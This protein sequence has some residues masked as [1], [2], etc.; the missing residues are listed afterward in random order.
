MPAWARIA[1]IAWLAIYVPVYAA[2]Y[3]ALHFLQLCD[4]G[5]LLA[6]LG[7][8]LGNRLLLSAQAIGAPG[9]ALLW[10]ADLGWTAISGH[11]LH[12]GTA[13]LWDASVPALARVLSLFHLVLPIALVLYL[14]R[15][16]Y[17]PRALP[18]QS[19]IAAAAIA[20]SW[21]FGS[22]QNLNYVTH[23]PNGAAVL[24]AIAG[25]HAFA[26]WLSLC[27]VIYLPTHLS[28]LNFLPAKRQAR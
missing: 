27:A 19:A 2:A 6:C 22:A 15:S 26:S 23:W 24:P 7:V 17:D 28:L 18:L 12:G 20:L 3:G 9:I 21:W 10:L 25:V 11:G 16:G 14:R 4:L 13:Y 5:V 1:V 8:L